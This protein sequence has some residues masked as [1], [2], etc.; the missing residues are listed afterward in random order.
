MYESLGQIE[1]KTGEQVELGLVRCP[2]LEWAEPVEK[3]L[4]HKRGVW[5]WQNTQVLRQE[6]GIEV[7]FYLLHRQGVPFANIMTAELEGVGHLGHVF[8]RPEDRRKGAVSQLM[9]AQMAHFRARQGRALFLGTGYDSPAYHI[10]RA[11]GFESI[12]PRSGYMAYFASSPDAFEADYFAGGAIAIQEVSWKHWPASAP[13]FTGDFPGVVRCA[14]LRLFGRNSTE[15]PFLDL[16][17]DEGERRENDQAPR[18]RVLVQQRSRA[19]VGLAM[20]D[21][22]PLWPE[23]CLVDVYCHPHYWG[24]APALLESLALPEAER[25]LAYADTTGP[26]KQ[27][28]LKAAGYRQTGQ[29]P[30]RVAVDHDRTQFADVTVWERE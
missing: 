8:T 7:Y 13:L 18:V 25:F 1:L 20:W 22:D 26:E 21:W 10:Y 11:Q 14:P 19:V 16:I 24:E 23:T 30:G 9:T 5:N 28:N 3:L 15:G 12:E 27:Q 2:D 6:T 4:E 29:Y 17:H